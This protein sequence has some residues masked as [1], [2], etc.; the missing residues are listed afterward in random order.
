MLSYTSLE[1]MWTLGVC[2]ITSKISKKSSLVFSIYFQFEPASSAVD[3]SLKFG[4]RNIRLVFIM[5]NNIYSTIKPG[6]Q[7][8]WDP[9]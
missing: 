1:V 5:G 4:G 3:Q 9:L 7:Q 6:G 2:E 8:D